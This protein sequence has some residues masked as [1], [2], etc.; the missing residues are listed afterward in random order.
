MRYIAVGPQDSPSVIRCSCKMKWGKKCSCVKVV[1]NSSHLCKERHG[2]ACTS[3]SA[4]EDNSDD[5]KIIQDI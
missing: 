4:F 2:V 3:T 5:H 1:L